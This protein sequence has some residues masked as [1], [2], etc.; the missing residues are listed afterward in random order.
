MKIADLPIPEDAKLII[1]KAGYEEL[2]P[3]QREAIEAGVLDG[4]NLVLASPT[5][6]GKTLVA[7]LC[8]ITH[9]VERGGKVLYLTPLRAL[10]SEKY[11]DFKKYTALRRKGGRRQMRASRRRTR[12]EQEGKI[13][14]GTG[15][16]RQ[17][18]DHPARA[19]M[20]TRGRKERDWQAPS[21]RLEGNARM[22]RCPS[23]A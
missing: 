18:A 3:P 15:Q 13:E 16:V 1:R 7:E 10:A 19:P 5:A 12:G 22:P 17:V 23:K 14:R 6:S 11:E 21:R 2:Y 9:I 8:A 4:K 20:R